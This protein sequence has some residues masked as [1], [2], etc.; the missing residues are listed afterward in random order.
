[1]SEMNGK[2]ILMTFWLESVKGHMDME[3]ASSH[4]ED[5]YMLQDIFDLQ[6]LSALNDRDKRSCSACNISGLLCMYSI[7]CP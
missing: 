5:E 6:L 7:T 1:M 3:M 4:L 2:A